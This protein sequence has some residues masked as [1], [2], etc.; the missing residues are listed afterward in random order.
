MF[1]HAL[2]WSYHP[3]DL[4]AVAEKLGEDYVAVSPAELVEPINAS[5]T[6]Q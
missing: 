4:V 3:S 2:S 1:V 5:L 6:K